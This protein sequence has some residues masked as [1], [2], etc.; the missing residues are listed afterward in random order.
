MGLREVVEALPRNNMH[1]Q[2]YLE[3]RYLSRVDVGAIPI[4]KGT[5]VVHP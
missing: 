3:L 4:G 2:R 5:G 1:M